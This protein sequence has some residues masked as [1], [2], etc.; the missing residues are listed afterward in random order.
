MGKEDDE[1]FDLK[2]FEIL[3]D[4]ATFCLMNARLNEFCK[5]N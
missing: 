1:T 4:F 3:I 2:Y 5:T